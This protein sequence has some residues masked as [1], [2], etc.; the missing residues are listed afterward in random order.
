RVLP[1]ILRAKALGSPT[2][3]A[4][5]S[6]QPLPTGWPASSNRPRP[7]ALVYWVSG[8]E[9][10][11]ATPLRSP[12]SARKP[13]R[14]SPVAV[15]HFETLSVLGQRGLPVGLLRLL[16]LKAVGSRPARRASPDADKPCLAAKRSRARQISE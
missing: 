1:L 15:R 5:T 7:P 12:M 6:S 16:L 4:S 10:A 9:R 3:G 13:P 14:D 8:S 11:K 2:P